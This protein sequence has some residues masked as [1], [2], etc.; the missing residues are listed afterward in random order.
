M[1]TVR[2]KDKKTTVSVRSVTATLCNPTDCTRQAPL[3]MGFP[4]QE[5]WSELPFP[6]PGDLPS[7]RIEPAPPALASGFFTTESAD[8]LQEYNH[9]QLNSQTDRGRGSPGSWLQ[10]RLGPPLAR[11]VEGAFVEPSPT[12]WVESE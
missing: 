10:G 11:L 8:N 9:Q 7:A 3:C 6:P 12:G 2:G 1:E 5:Y 4:R